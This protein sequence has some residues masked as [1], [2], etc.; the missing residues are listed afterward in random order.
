VILA[1]AATVWAAGGL[2]PRQEMIAAAEELAEVDPAL[3]RAPGWRLQDLPNV[4][5]E[6]RTL[7]EAARE[8]I[9]AEVDR[10]LDLTRREAAPAQQP[11]GVRVEGEKEH[12]KLRGEARREATRAQGAARGSSVVKERHQKEGKPDN[13]PGRIMELSGGAR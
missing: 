7:Q 4:G 5:D 13:P 3:T 10:E 12:D 8:A 11:G 1:C 6:A 2:S 9:Q